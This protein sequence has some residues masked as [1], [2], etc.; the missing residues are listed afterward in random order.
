MNTALT[1][2]LIICSIA[3]A[4][5]LIRAMIGSQSRKEEQAAIWASM[6]EGVLVVDSRRQISNL[7]RAAMA[8]LGISHPAAILGHRLDSLPNAAV[9][10]EVCDRVSSE[11]QPAE[12]EFSPSGNKELLLQ[13]RGSKLKRP[14]GADAGTVIVLND[15]TRIR[16]LETLRR[17]FAANVSHELRTP[18][19]SIKGFVETLLDGA[20]ADP[21]ETRRF[22][23]IILGQANRLQ[24]I[25]EDL[26]SLARLEQGV[27]QRDIDFDAANIRS[28]LE[29]A[30]K[31][32]TPKAAEKRITLRLESPADIAAR[33][34]STLLEQAV[35][36]LIDNAIKYSPEGGT[37]DV[38]LQ[39]TE[40]EAIISVRDQG[41]GIS[42]AHLPRIF[43][44][45][46]RVD[47]SRSRKV[48][49]TGLGLSIVKHVALAHHGRV[50]VESTEGIGSTFSLALPLAGPAEPPT[51]FPAASTE[52][53][54]HASHQTLFPR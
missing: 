6:A 40:K 37:I 38:G 8:L 48:G 21:A 4:L 31:A 10:A 22:L 51:G 11:P 45:F 41:C 12:A 24:A 49:G 5:F 7:N 42:A 2:C 54:P 47:K 53:A 52:A 20:M 36:N 19:T 29:A 44:R 46:Y 9:F 18:V 43:E 28:T 15:I 13:V 23:L 30:V 3:T 50:H 1:I 17:D 26:L 32:G 16:R 14:D 33:I 35:L 39:R 27:E 25:I 34:N